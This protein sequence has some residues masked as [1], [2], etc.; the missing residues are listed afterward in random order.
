MPVNLLSVQITDDDGDTN[1]CIVHLPSGKTLAQ[2]QAISDVLVSRIDNVINGQITASRME[3]NFSLP[4]G[5]KAAPVQ[6]SENQ[7]GAQFNFET[8]GQY[9]HGFRVPSFAD[10]KFDGDNVIQTDAQ[11]AALITGMVDGVADGIGTTQ[12][13]SKYGEDLTSVRTAVKAFRRK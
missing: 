12:P 2:Y 5:L 1:S 11:V 10:A 13:V 3:V 9:S 4:V 6:Y 7:K 8:D